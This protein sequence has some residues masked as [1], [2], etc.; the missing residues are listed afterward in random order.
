MTDHGRFEVQRW[1]RA[2]AL[3]DDV[4]ALLCELGVPG[5]EAH[6]AVQRG[7]PRQRRQL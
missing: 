7:G 4:I 2:E 5:A 1:L 6:A 3:E